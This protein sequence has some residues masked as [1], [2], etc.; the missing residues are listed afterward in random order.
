MG[1]LLRAPRIRDN[2]LVDSFDKQPYLIGELLELRPMRPEDW[3]PLFAV[4]SDPMIW[5]VH[6][7]RDRHKE[8]RFR[9]YFQEALESGGALVAIDRDTRQV[10]GASRYFWQGSDPRELEIGWTFLACA[11]WG[12]LYNKEMKRLMVD[13]AFQFVDHVIFLVDLANVRSQ[14]AMLKVGGVLTE[15]RVERSL[16]GKSSEYVV[17]EIRRPEATA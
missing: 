17:F 3:E 11:Y 12:G 13:H 14:R 6:P 7:A 4:A 5:E 8:E 9:D 2:S 15:R 10:I 1:R 16:G